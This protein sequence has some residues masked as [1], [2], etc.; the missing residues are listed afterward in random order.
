VSA[1]QKKQFEQYEPAESFVGLTAEIPE[2]EDSDE[3][4]EALQGRAD[5]LVRQDI[6]RR[7]ALYRSKTEDEE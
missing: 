7:Y 5:E 2:S 3:F 4:I 1:S 6:I